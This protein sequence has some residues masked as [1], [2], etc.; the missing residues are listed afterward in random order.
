[1]TAPGDEPVRLIEQE[2]DAE[3]AGVGRRGT[4]YRAPARRRCYRLITPTEIGADH[5]DELKRWQHLGSRAG[6]A[7]VVPADAA[8]DQQRLGGRWYQ[9]VCY[10]TSGGRSLADAIADPDPAR[11]VDARTSGSST[12]CPVSPPGSP[13]NASSAPPRTGWT[14]R[15]TSPTATNA[16]AGPGTATA[17]PSATWTCWKTRTRSTCRRWSTRSTC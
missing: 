9:V 17:R 6:L 14:P 11:R 10:E 7:P 2:L 4:L 15:P 16:S 5:R 3:Y 8:G 1:M 13:S 12:T